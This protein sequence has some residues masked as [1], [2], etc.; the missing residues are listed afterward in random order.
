MCQGVHTCKWTEHYQLP[1]ITQFEW[2]MS[3][4]QVQC[5][6]KCNR[7][8]NTFNEVQYQSWSL[9]LEMDYKQG[10]KKSSAHLTGI[11]FA[12]WWAVIHSVNLH[13]MSRPMI[14]F[15]SFLDALA[16]VRK[17]T[18]SLVMSVRPSAWNN[19]APT[20]RIFMKFDMRVF[21]ENIS[22]KFKHH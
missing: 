18:V 21:F 17:A 14:Q 4:Q 1:S 10:M 22:R 15:L 8:Q 6:K 3:G 7:L 11:D 2:Q 5:H 9:T 12:K 19:L 16:K 20:G 13:Q